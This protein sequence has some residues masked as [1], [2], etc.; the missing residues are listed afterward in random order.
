[1]SS[2]TALK[3]AAEHKQEGNDALIAA[4]EAFDEAG[5]NRAR[6][7]VAT[8]ANEIFDE[9][10]ETPLIYATTLSPDVKA[11]RKEDAQDSLMDAYKAYKAANELAVAERVARLGKEVMGEEAWEEALAEEE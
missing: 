6:D 11:V 1:M 3:T 7:A 9:P 2:S 5:E 4:F 8:I 10:I